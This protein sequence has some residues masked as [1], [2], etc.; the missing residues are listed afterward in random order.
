MLRKQADAVVRLLPSCILAVPLRLQCRTEWNQTWGPK[1]PDARWRGLRSNNRNLS[2]WKFSRGDG[3]ILGDVWAEADWPLDGHAVM[4]GTSRPYILDAGTSFIV[5]WKHHIS[6]SRSLWKKVCLSIQEGITRNLWFSAWAFT[7]PHAPVQR[8]RSQWLPLL[9]LARIRNGF[10]KEFPGWLWRLVHTHYG[11]PN[12]DPEDLRS[13]NHQGF[14]WV[15]YCV[16]V[17]AGHGPGRF[18]HG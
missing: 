16:H 2:K 14:G 6:M 10:K 7:H 13:L 4:V 12:E 17:K 11:I 1:K 3:E 8:E 5:Y 18:Y 9:S 15:S